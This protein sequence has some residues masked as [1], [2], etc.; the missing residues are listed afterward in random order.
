MHRSTHNI[1]YIFNKMYLRFHK[2]DYIKKVFF[3]A[4]RT[5]STVSSRESRLRRILR[6]FIA[7]LRDKTPQLQPRF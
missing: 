1:I 4:E 3:I 7:C 6:A 2:N 5:I